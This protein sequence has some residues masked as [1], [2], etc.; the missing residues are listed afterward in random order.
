MA[1][2]RFKVILKALLFFVL[3]LTATTEAT[4]RISD[5]MERRLASQPPCRKLSGALGPK[6]VIARND[7]AS[8]EQDSNGKDR[9]LA[10][11]PPC[12]KLR[13]LAEEPVHAKAYDNPRCHNYL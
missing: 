2:Y 6:Q 7:A 13:A 10:T 5:V 3:L 1:S 12:R 8:S 4:R 11:Q 9:R